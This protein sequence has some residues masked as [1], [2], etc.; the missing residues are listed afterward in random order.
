[1]KT[2]KIALV[3]LAIAAVLYI[4]LPSLSW[5]EDATAFSK[6]QW[7]GFYCTRIPVGSGEFARKSG[8]NL[9]VTTVCESKLDAAP[10]KVE[11]P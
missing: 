10:G 1:M 11:K 6:G 3:I 8:S 2:T 4:L 5:A 9:G 7:S